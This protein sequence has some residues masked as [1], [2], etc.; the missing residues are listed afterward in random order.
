M[1]ARIRTLLSSIIFTGDMVL[2]TPLKSQV[3]KKKF[4][5]RLQ[6][7]IAFFFIRLVSRT[8]YI[9]VVM[10]FGK[11]TFLSTEPPRGRVIELKDFEDQDILVRRRKEPWTA[12]QKKKMQKEWRTKYWNRPYDIPQLAV[13]LGHWLLGIRRDRMI[14]E[15]HKNRYVCSHTQAG[16]ERAT[17]V[18]TYGRIHTARVNPGDCLR[19]KHYETI[20]RI[21]KGKIKYINI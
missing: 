3:R 4:L 15:P 1:N 11:G 5:Q 19:N 10:A 16:L 8:H 17:G 9:H 18:N 6:Y 14:W 2:T 13:M 20:L 21:R 12:A 7:A